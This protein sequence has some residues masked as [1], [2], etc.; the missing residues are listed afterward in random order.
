MIPS[1][2]FDR[3]K[4]DLTLFAGLGGDSWS[5]AFPSLAGVYVAGALVSTMLELVTVSRSA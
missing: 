4:I 3:M 2:D 1:L 5:I